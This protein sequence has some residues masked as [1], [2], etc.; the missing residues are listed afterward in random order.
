MFVYCDL[1][2]GMGHLYNSILG[3]VT[4]IVLGLM[5]YFY[6]FIYHKYELLM[7]N[8]LLDILLP[9]HLPLK[10]KFSY[11]NLFVSVKMKSQFL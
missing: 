10:V 9:T 7:Y 6:L 4:K 5:S 11:L 3:P 8:K 1:I 2:S